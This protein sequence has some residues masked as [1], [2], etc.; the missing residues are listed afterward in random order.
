MLAPQV[1]P[2]FQAT[3]VACKMRGRLSATKSAKT[4]VASEG[5]VGELFGGFT[6][7]GI[8]GL[9]HSYSSP[10]SVSGRGVFPL[11]T[12]QHAW[13]RVNTRLAGRVNNVRGGTGP[14]LGEL[15]CWPVAPTSP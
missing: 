15:T 13:G 14:V 11:R 8:A 12:P 9:L 4:L 7:A 1:W 2:A 5:K 3:R 6:G 10:G